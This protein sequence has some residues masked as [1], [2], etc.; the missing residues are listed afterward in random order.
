MGISRRCCGSSAIIRLRP[1]SRL[2]QRWRRNVSKG[3]LV[4]SRL[5]HTDTDSYTD[6]YTD[7]DAE[8]GDL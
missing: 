7:A 1:G 4:V 5:D 8:R 2:E 3:W 6:A